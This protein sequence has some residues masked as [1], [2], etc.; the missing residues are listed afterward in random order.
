MQE[1][2]RQLIKWEI[3]T[4]L[5]ANIGDTVCEKCANDASRDTVIIMKYNDLSIWNSIYFWQ[6]L[7]SDWVHSVEENPFYN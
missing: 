3:T 5:W 4:L 2:L 7:Y 6:Y 1:I